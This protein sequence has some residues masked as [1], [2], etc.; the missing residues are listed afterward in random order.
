MKIEQEREAS[1]MT[2]P[3]VE[4]STE[5]KKFVQTRQMFK[6][7]NDEKRKVFTIGFSM[8]G[9]LRSAYNHVL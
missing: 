9:E 5:N 2:A 7:I 6:T 8:A 3:A 1:T 4:F